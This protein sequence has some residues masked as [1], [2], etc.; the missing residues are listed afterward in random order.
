MRYYFHLRESETYLVDE[1]GLELNGTD[2]IVAA[3]TAGARSV[4]ANEVI[5]GK[6]PLMAVIE[7]DDQTGR[8]VLELPFRDAV[9][10]DG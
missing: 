9:Q 6:L 5:R 1:E 4:I 3:A 7:V 10:L 2:A 8:R